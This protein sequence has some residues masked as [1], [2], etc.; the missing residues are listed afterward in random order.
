MT[1]AS[2]GDWEVVHTVHDYHDAPRSG[3]ADFRGGPHAYACEW[4][5]AEDGWSRFYKLSPITDEQFAAA[6]EGRAI[7]RRWRTAHDAG[8]LGPGDEHPVLAA[9]RPRFEALRQQLDDALK[10]DN[11]AAIR[12]TAKFRGNW[13]APD[14][15]HVQWS[16]R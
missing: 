3:I 8:T 2:D 4:S 10:L 9:D 5:E 15:L 7:W 11:S 14:D 12:C 16:P 6:M 13:D 1:K